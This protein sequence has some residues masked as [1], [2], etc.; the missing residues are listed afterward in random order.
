VVYEE[1]DEVKLINGDSYFGI[2]SDSISINP[3][4]LTKYNNLIVNNFLIIE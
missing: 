3:D 2:K 4:D 1:I